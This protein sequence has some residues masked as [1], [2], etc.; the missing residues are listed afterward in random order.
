M[1]EPRQ[2]RD[3]RHR[4]VRH[5]AGAVAGIRQGSERDPRRRAG[6]RLRRDPAGQGPPA[7][8]RGRAPRAAARGDRDDARR[9]ATP[10]ASEGR[11]GPGL[12]TSASRAADAAASWPPAD[13]RGVVWGAVP[14]PRA[15]PVASEGRV[16][17]GLDTSASR[18]ADAAASWPPADV[19]GVV[20]DAVAVLRAHP[21]AAFI[22]SII[23]GFAC[24][25][26]ELL[27]STL[28]VVGA[29]LLSTL[30]SAAALNLY[31]AYAERLMEEVSKGT[32]DF[33]LLHVVRLHGRAQRILPALVVASFV[34]PALSVSALGLLIVPGLW[35]L[36][37][38][39]VVVPVISN[40]VVGPITALKRSNALVRGSSWQV[41]RTATIALLLEEGLVHAASAAGREAI[42]SNYWS[43]W[44]VSSAAAALVI[45]ITALTVSSVF[46]RLMRREL[47]RSLAVEGA[48]TR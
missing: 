28:T 39:A 35:L 16:G 2:E 8:G 36:T 15:T 46:S 27:S 48:A 14:G 3:G 20:W 29:E 13:V 23:L 5:A 21:F 25:S 32:D 7:G 1:R 10:V 19:R 31:L 12:D 22:P 43:P 11:V 41:F 33:T 45:P 24:Q 37:R 4:R 34:T 38:W 26:A 47:D 42:S 9:R 40:E 18:A 30:T 44:V 6:L 17:P